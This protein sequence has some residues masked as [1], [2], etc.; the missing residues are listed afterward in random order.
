MMVTGDI[1]EIFV[2]NLNTGEVRKLGR[3]GPIGYDWDVGSV[4]SFNLTGEV[5]NDYE[6]YCITKSEEELAVDLKPI[7]TITEDGISFYGPNGDML[8]C[9]SKKGETCTKMEEGDNNMEH[10]K[11]IKLYEEK[12]EAKIKDAFKEEYNA[13]LNG[14]AFIREFNNLTQAF[15]QG[16]NDLYNLQNPSEEV[17]VP[18]GYLNAYKFEI[19]TGFKDMIYKQVDEKYEKIRQ[20]LDTKIS[21]LKAHL[22]LLDAYGCSDGTYEAIMGNLIH[23]GIIDLMGHV[24]EFEFESEKKNVASKNNIKSTKKRG[25]KPKK[26]TENAEIE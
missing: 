3:C 1:N 15:E 13:V 24:Q 18:T 11:L 16:L 17:I 26:D 8:S 4:V 19:S 5:L 6:K 21:E 2:K 25:R 10:I 23:Y 9:I 7:M 14:N 22:E 12:A 20:E